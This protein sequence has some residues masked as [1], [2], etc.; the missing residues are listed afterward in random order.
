MRRAM[1]EVRWQPLDGATPAQWLDRFCAGALL[2]GE[3]PPGHLPGGFLDRRQEVCL[4]VRAIE[5]DLAEAGG[6]AVFD[7]EALAAAAQGADG[8]ARTWQMRLAA[9][10]GD[11]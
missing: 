5:A 1:G 9:G 8:L 7:I 3:L 4:W 6:E 10:E 11:A 2:R